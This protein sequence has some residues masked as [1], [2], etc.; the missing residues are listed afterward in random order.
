M[1]AALSALTALKPDGVQLTPGNQPTK[2]FADAA[3]ALPT[4]THHGFTF[5]AFRTRTIWAEGKCLVG[6]DSVHPPASAE[7]PIDWGS[8]LP[9]LETMYPGYRLGTGAELDA[10]MDRGVPLAVDVSHLFIQQQQGV[11]GPRTLARI[12]DYPRIAEVHVSANDGRRDLHHPLTE[13]S[14]GLAWA[15]AKRA[16]GTPVILECY[17]HRLTRDQRERQAD[18]VRA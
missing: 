1:G 2:H 11:L 6:S 10:A 18:L 12:L 14:F 7:A 4:R 15:R 8:P 3:R 5:A 9:V 17:F 16:A 13:S